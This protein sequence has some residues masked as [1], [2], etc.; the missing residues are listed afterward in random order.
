[1]RRGEEGGGAEG[2]GGCLQGPAG[3]LSAFLS[4]WKIPPSILRLCSTRGL[5]RLHG[6]R[7]IITPLKVLS[8]KEYVGA[9]CSE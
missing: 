2:P 8:L 6:Q 5:Q 9:R 1:M 4:G 7:V 3:G